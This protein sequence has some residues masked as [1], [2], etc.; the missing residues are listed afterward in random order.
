ME[1]VF[2]RSLESSAKTTLLERLLSFP[3]VVAAAFA[4]LVDCMVPSSMADP[5]IWWHLRNAETLFRSH[6]F[7]VSDNFSFTALGAP[8]INHE[9]LAEIPF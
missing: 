9:W 6:R 8:W 7:I 4:A 2:G 3:F 1:A 5:D